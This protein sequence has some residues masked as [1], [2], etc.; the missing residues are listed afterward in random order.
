MARRFLA[1]G[2]AM[3][4]LAAGVAAA[5]PHDVDPRGP[6]DSPDK[7]P[8][9]ALATAGAKSASIDAASAVKSIRFILETSLDVGGRLVGRT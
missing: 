6:C 3:L 1:L 7:R 5:A 2:L 8:W 4:A 9:R